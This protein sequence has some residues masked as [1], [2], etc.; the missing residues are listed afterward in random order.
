MYKNIQINQTVSFLDEQLTSCYLKIVDVSIQSIASLA[1]AYNVKI[2][3][4][5]ALSESNP[6]WNISVLEI[7][8]SSIIQFTAEFSQGDLMLKISEALKTKLLELNP[9]WLAENIIIEN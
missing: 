2:Y 1:A 7:P 3:K 6:E 9:T 5:K 8:N 4:T